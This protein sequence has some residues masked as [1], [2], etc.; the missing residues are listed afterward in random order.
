MTLCRKMHALR[1]MCVPL[2]GVFVNVSGYS[3]AGFGS[4][5]DPAAALSTAAAGLYAR[6][7]AG[8]R[9][10][11]EDGQALQELWAWNL[12]SDDPDL[13]G[14]PVV[15]DPRRAVRNRATAAME[16]LARRAAQMTQ[17]PEL[18]DQLVAHYERARIR[19]G[20][21]CEYLD[22]P[23]EVNARI[24][25]ALAGAEHELLTAQP[26][27]PRTRE[28]L[29]IALR[30][31]SQALARGVK[32]RTLYLDNVR[33]DPVTRE[34][35]TEMTRLGAQYRTISSPF[36]RCIII[37]RRHAFIDDY[38]QDG[39]ANAAW[40]VQDEAM[41]AW[42]AAV[43]DGTWA[44]AEPWHGDVRV[45]GLGVGVG[46]GPRTTRQQR[47]ILRDVC[48]GV[49]QAKT[50]ARLQWSVRRVAKALEELRA[51]FGVPTTTALA[52][53]WATHPERLI[54]EQPLGRGDVTPA[55]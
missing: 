20:M 21:G 10:G 41:V 19:P 1:A 8:G 30:R 25:A 15:L 7:A 31:D 51:M 44:R 32:V 52:Y 3:P 34:W 4:S 14:E 39:P 2:T 13:P 23:A 40:Y 46:A 49:S 11:P 53:V 12:V 36:Q 9:P 47:E 5:P 28:L 45:A 55:A 17:M 42:I 16:A 6:I 26:G 33:T 50:A 24:G 27:G 18:A 43:F 22:S 48:H 54:D 37:D 35:C 38:V 29:Q